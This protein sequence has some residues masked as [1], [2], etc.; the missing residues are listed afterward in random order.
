MEIQTTI[1]MN[2]MI[3]MELT[4]ASTNLRLSRTYIIRLLLKHFLDDS[5]RMKIFQSP[6]KYQ[7]RDDI[8]NWSTFHIT[9]REDEYELCL[10]LRKVYKMSLSLMIAFAVRKYL[11][12][13]IVIFST[14]TPEYISDNYL[15]RNYGFSLNIING[16]KCIRIYWG[17]SNLE[18]LLTDNYQNII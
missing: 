6:V 13:I 16:I 12:R 18:D 5:K 9:L 17:I 2:K 15:Y 3:M 11:K 7:A 8:S 14:R 10:D 4:Q 1:N